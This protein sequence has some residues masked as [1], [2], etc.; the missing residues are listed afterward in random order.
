MRDDRVISAALAAYFW[1]TK[2]KNNMIS[3]RRTREAEAAK[4][5]ASI[6]DQ[7]ALFNRNRLDMFFAHKRQV[8]QVQQRAMTR[9][10]WR[11]R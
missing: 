10:A 6:V 11:Y 8:R 4:K 2:L 9:N 7:V 1:D 3:Q 5:R